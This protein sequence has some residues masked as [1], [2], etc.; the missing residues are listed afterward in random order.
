[1]GM[2]A[3]EL[4]RGLFRILETG[5]G[6]LAADVVHAEFRNRE[7]AVSPEAC[8]IP[9]PAGVLASGAW[10][11]SA[12]SDL[13]FVVTDVADTGDQVWVRLRMQGRH[14]GPFIKFRDGALDQAVPPTGREIDFEQIHVLGLRDGKVVS[15]EAVR[16]DVTMLGQLGVFPPE[17][18]GMLRM[19]GWKLTGRAKRSAQL[20][21]TQAAEAAAQA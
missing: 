15:H 13:R 11:R 20:V 7:A 2:D 6:A 4:G 21:T 12:F 10:M 8:S 16:D 9:G 3:S 17:P 18:A 5:D 14:T 1:M 19:V